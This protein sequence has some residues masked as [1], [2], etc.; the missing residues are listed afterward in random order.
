MYNWC[1]GC[2]VDKP[3]RPYPEFP[4]FAHSSGK[5]A[6]KVSGQTKYF[7]RWDD[8]AAA[9]AEYEA[10]VA[11]N[12]ATVARSRGLALDE[13]CNR[14]LDS[15]RTRVEAGELGDVTFHEYRRMCKR[16]LALWGRERV[17]E[18]LVPADFAA[19]RDDRGRHWNIVAVGNEVTRVRSLFRW[20][21]ESRLINEPI[22]FGPDFKRASAKSLR[23]L[24]REQGAKLYT[25]A[26]IHRML[27]EAG[28]NMRAWI[29]LG[30]NCG[31]GPGDCS[32]LPAAAVDLDR[33]WVSFPRPKTEV[34]RECPLWP[35]TVTAL[36]LAKSS[37]E[38]LFL[39]HGGKIFD[40]L[41]ISKRFRHVRNW[42][43][44]NRGGLYWLRHCFQTVAG[45]AKDEVAVRAIMGHAD[46]SMSAVY[47]EE[48]EDSR[49]RAVVAHVRSWLLNAN[50]SGT[51]SRS[52]R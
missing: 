25:A 24:R 5:W 13:A 3:R 45:G 48:V 16:L 14:F 17:V 33:G 50:T 9:L 30:I 21:A 35:E 20:L 23:R 29:L 36:Q 31:Y 52:S 12:C 26:Q 6:K 10:F 42:A 51:H 41:T 22:H 1:S 43:G 7:G 11:G 15:K 32:T 49:L 8:P 18:S 34:P 47:R 19:Y 4:L 44:I 37:G 39:R 27:A 2:I 46:A 40:S 38:R 28:N